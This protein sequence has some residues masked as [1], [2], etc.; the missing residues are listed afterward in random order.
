MADLVAVMQRRPA[1]AAGAAGASSTPA[2]PTCS[3]PSFCGSP[4]MNVLDGRGR[5]TALPPPAGRACR[6]RRPATRGPV[7][8]GL[9]PRARARWSTPGAAGV[10]A[11]ARSTW[12]S[13]SATRRSSRSASATSW[14]TCAQPA[15]V[16]ARPSA[17][18]AACGPTA[19]RLHLFDP[20]TEAAIEDGRRD[21]S[22]ATEPR[23]PERSE[24][25]D[26]TSSERQPGGR[27]GYTRA[28]G[29][30]AARS[31]PAPCCRWQRLAGA[32]AEASSSAAPRPAAAARRRA[33][34]SPIGSFS[35][36]AM[37]PFRDV[38]L[39]KFTARR[40]ASPPSTT[41][42]TTTPGTRTRKNDGLQKTG[43]YDIYVMD[44]NWVPEF[45]AG[46]IIQSLDSSA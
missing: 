9:P 35:D 16:R 42:P 17:A 30:R 28:S 38:F 37:V 40:P 14:S 45:A 25:D 20:D 21:P 22:P 1:A 44:D 18:P 12:S 32:R 6:C 15:G 4:P 3:S 33:A 2:R 10:A 23:Q 29:D 26:G 36:P 24:P 39:K 46:G 8:L 5:R 31:V 27:G 11:P 41:R 13:R 34:R 7:K 43:A 19:G